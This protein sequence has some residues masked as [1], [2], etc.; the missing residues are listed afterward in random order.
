MHIQYML[1]CDWEP[2]T[3]RFERSPAF[4]KVRI[5]TEVSDRLMTEWAT[6]SQRRCGC[7]YKYGHVE[8]DLAGDCVAYIQWAC[9]EC[10]PDLVNMMVK[11][12]PGVSAVTVGHRPVVSQSGSDGAWVAVPA[13]DVELED[14]S[15][16]AIRGFSVARCPV[17]ISQFAEFARSTQHKSTAEI[18]GSR[19]TYMI[20][21]RT[22]YEASGPRLDTDALCVSYVD[23][24]AYCEWSDCRLPTEREW[25]AAAVPKAPNSE[26]GVTPQTV[27]KHPDT[28][29]FGGS[30]WT[31]SR[32]VCSNQDEKI[33]V[34]SGP[35][36]TRRANWRDRINVHRKMMERTYFGVM[37]CFRCV[38]NM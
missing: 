19:S 10:I 22:E 36:Y 13:Q 34:R 24:L 6:N 15:S 9:P 1:N 11:D 3:I 7:T 14:G 4:K 21:P 37:L 25:I 8:Q 32:I 31:G 26:P 35:V 27:A 23:A 28:L 29:Q 20:N 33:I 5:N 16:E 18:V 38:R 17:T 12:V 2:V 30:E